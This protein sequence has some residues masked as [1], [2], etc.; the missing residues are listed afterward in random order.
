MAE[1]AVYTKPTSQL[2]LEARLERDNEN[3]AAHVP[4]YSNPASFGVEDYV[5]TDPVY[6]NHANDT[7]APLKAEGG[8]EQKAEEFFRETHESHLQDPP[9]ARDEPDVKDPVEIAQE[10]HERNLAAYEV[11]QEQI[12]SDAA[13]PFAA[14]EVE[15]EAPEEPAD[16]SGSQSPFSS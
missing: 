3:P 9:P 16:E 10:Q 5:G 1:E 7:E 4:G 8:A 2:D 6:Q 14:T 11:R 12:K 13:G 15:E